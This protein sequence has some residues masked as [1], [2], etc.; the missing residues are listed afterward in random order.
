MANGTKLRVN[1]VLGLK[2]R[3]EPVPTHPWSV[4]VPHG[5]VVE[6]IGEPS[7]YDSR[8]TFQKARTE[9]GL[10]GWLT[11]RDGE[12]VYLIRV[13]EG[14]ASDNGKR[15]RVVWQQGLKLRSEALPTGSSSIVVPVGTV[16]TSLGEPFSHVQGYVFQRVRT[17]Q[18]Q[19]GWLTRSHRDEVYLVRLDDQDDEPEAPDEETG[20]MW[21]IWSVGL[22]LR[23]EPVP[24][25]HSDVVLPY[26]TQVTT[27]G[28]PFDH[29]DGYRF[30]KVRLEDGRGC[31]LL[32][33]GPGLMHHH[34]P[35]R[36][37]AVFQ[38]VPLSD[39]HDEG[40]DLFLLLEVSF[41]EKHI[42]ITEPAK[43][44]PSFGQLFLNDLNAKLF[45][46]R[47]QLH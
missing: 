36:V 38:A 5:A 13:A 34:V 24:S 23:S 4:I 30:Q 1:N 6:A 3:G 9:E 35:R 27:L 33:C 42:L 40:P 18:G 31:V 45:R 15:F 12:T 20:T 19:V 8:F 46:Q 11:F 17:P 32:A 14:W 47:F 16:V 39:V 25:L 22:K 10:E 21:V 26:G 37:N 41:D 28:E 2:L 7:Q 29:P 43:T 44:T